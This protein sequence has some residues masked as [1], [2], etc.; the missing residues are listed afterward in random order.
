MHSGIFVAASAAIAELMP[1]KTGDLTYLRLIR[2]V[3]LIYLFEIIYL[4]I[5]CP[6]KIFETYCLVVVEILKASFG[7]FW[8]GQD[9]D[10][11]R[12][13]IKHVSVRVQ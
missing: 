7:V 6:D 11:A 2:T 5:L 13:L 12:S 4:Y 9:T 3:N 10:V 8:G 1:S